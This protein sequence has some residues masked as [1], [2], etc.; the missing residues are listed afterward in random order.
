MGRVLIAWKASLKS[1]DSSS[2]VNSVLSSN[3]NYLNKIFPKNEHVKVV[4][5]VVLKC[6]FRDALCFNPITCIIIV[7]VYNDVIDA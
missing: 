6:K 5:I 4:A 7:C 1:E 2:Q 3:T